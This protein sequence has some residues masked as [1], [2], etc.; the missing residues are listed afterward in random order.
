MI[1]GFQ[2]FLFFVYLFERIISSEE[3]KEEVPICGGFIE[4]DSNISQEI[5]KEIDYSSIQVQSFTNDMI[6]KD[7][8][9]LAQSGYY[10]LPIYENESFILKIN[11]PNGMSFGIWSYKILE[12]EQ[13]V[14]NIDQDRNIKQICVG[15][16]NFKFKGF[17]V[18]GNIITRGSDTG[19]EGVNLGLFD[20]TETTKIQ[21]TKT[22]E[23][24]NFYFKPIIPGSYII[25]PI[26]TTLNFERGNEEFKFN[27]NINKSNFFNK[28]LVI[29][30]FKLIGSVEAD[31]DPL[32]NVL[33]L[34]YSLDNQLI[35]NFECEEAVSFELSNY[36]LNGITPFCVTTTNNKGLFTFSNIPFGKFTVRP[37]YADQHI[38][39]EVEPE[40]KE[41]QI[42]HSDF[43]FENPFQ[44]TNFSI[45]GKVVNSLKIGIP[46][47]TIKIDGQVKTITDKNGIYKLEHL[48]AGNYDLEATA[49]DYFFEPLTNLRITAHLKYL[50]DVVVTDYRLCGKILIECILSFYLKLVTTSLLRKEQ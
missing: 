44:V 50:P 11:G 33:I 32:E 19:P 20:K 40:L 14:F 3:L 18:A 34:I 28:V 16:I 13:Y 29:N 45:F 7:Q 17:S 31:Q 41:I 24:G 1:K 37:Y 35:K 5:K 27:I 42:E 12:P 21:T 2:V 23:G 9:F 43:V 30:G 36:P 10:F 46:N 49:D 6:L 8:T 38:T 47:V 26:D 25:K 39:Y 4:F 48:S 22:V 15:D